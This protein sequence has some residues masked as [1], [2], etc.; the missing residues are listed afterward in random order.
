MEQTARMQPALD[1]LLAATRRSAPDSAER[2]DTADL[3]AL[4]AGTLDAA[5]ADAVQAALL[6]DPEGRALLLE[7]ADAAPAR[8]RWPIVLAV[9]ALLLAGVIG[10]L[11]LRSGPRWV[12]DPM[13]GVQQVRD[14]PAPTATPPLFRPQT[15]VPLVLRPEHATDARPPVSI[16]VTGAG[17]ARAI[18]PAGTWA[19]TGVWRW[20]P[21]ARDLFGAQPGA[22]T[23]EIWFGDDAVKIPVRYQVA[24]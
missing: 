7:L 16:S 4:R 11:L 3:M 6:D 14:T 24:P 15:P 13:M 8:R 1:D 18:E 17:P 2:V 21:L 20:T 19:A 9:A 5:R 10:G 12:A 22:Y 23:I